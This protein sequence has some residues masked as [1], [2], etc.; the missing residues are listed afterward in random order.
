MLPADATALKRT[1]KKTL[2]HQPLLNINGNAL[3]PSTC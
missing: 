3:V 2:A 1:D